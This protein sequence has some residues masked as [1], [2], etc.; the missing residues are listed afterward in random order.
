MPL[1]RWREEFR[2]HQGWESPSQ[3][4]FQRT[5]CTFR[6][7]GRK[8][9]FLPEQTNRPP[10]EKDFLLAVAAT[11]TRLDISQFVSKYLE[12]W[13]KKKPDSKILGL[14][15]VVIDSREWLRIELTTED[16]GIAQ[17]VVF[18][19]YGGRGVMHG[20]LCLMPANLR[21]TVMPALAK[22]ISG[23]RFPKNV[24]CRRAVGAYLSGGE[25]SSRK[26]AG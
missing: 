10:E 17:I 25:I 24:G 5:S 7:R 9:P 1:S 6:L 20:I 8:F 23:F 16:R 3:A 12:T 2:R 11:T 18:Y 22:E 14:Q 4:I 21:N 26:E 15:T 13:K 19:L